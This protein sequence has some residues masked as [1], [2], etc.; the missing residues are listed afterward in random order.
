MDDA[1]KRSQAPSLRTLAEARERYVEQRRAFDQILQAA[2]AV[3]AAV[4]GTPA[5]SDSAYKGAVL[6]T[7]ALVHSVAL[8][9]ISPSFRAGRQ[10]YDVA[11]TAVLTRALAETYV[12][13]RYYA[14]EPNCKDDA[15]FRA[16][17]AEFHQRSKQHKIIS[18]FGITGPA[19]EHAAK[20]L[21]EA[22]VALGA[23]ARFEAQS[24]PDRRR[25]LDGERS[26]H[27]TLEDIAEGAGIHRDVWGSVYVFL[28]QFTH[29]SPM[30]VQYLAQLRA[31]E[32]IAH[33]NLSMM[34]QLASAFLG[35]LIIDLE[36][37]FPGC[38]A[39]ITGEQRDQ[40]SVET[41]VLEQMAPGVMPDPL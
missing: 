5:P 3:D 11:S 1:T 38:G 21:G 30:S 27:R 31:D 41:Q 32:P 26:S 6:F 19:L 36:Q 15:D 22:R 34:L 18:R 33:S 7:K 37:L 20:K 14:V 13:F 24:Q 10:L 29:S 39:A 9:K 25:Q 17:L 16:L 23:N 8:D 4:S 12:A 2:H 28:S 40:I 35:K